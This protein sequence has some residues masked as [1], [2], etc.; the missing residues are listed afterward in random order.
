MMTAR[1]LTLGTAAVLALFACEG[2][3][4]PEGPQGP[5]GPQGVQG[6]QGSQGVPGVSPSA[7]LYRGTLDSV[8][9]GG[10]IFSNTYLTRSIVNCWISQDGIAWLQLAT[11]TNG[12]AGAA[13]GA[14]Q[15]GT[16]LS[17]AIVGA[18]PRWRFIIVVVPYA[19]SGDR[20]DAQKVADRE[21]ERIKRLRR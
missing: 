9:E 20:E 7:L 10:A 5:Q 3:M 13:C 16:S 21:A 6:P 15:N 19:A 1:H 17:V 8:G 11:D 4:G 12:E 2:P 14:L 18:P